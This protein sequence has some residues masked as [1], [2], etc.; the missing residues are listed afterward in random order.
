MLVAAPREVREAK[1][2]TVITRFDAQA[3]REFGASV[4]MSYGLERRHATVTANILVEADL[5]GHRTH[6]L[7]LLSNYV[8]A[9]AGG[10]M[11]K[12]GEPTVVNDTG[13]QA[14]WDARLLPG[15]SVIVDA[16]SVAVERAERHGVVTIVIRNSQ[17]TGC[18]AAYLGT[19]VE[20]GLFVVLTAANTRG[21]RI[22]PFGGLEPVFSPSP[23]AVGIPNGQD[24]ILVDVTM[25][26]VANSVVRQHHQRG[27]RLPSPWLQDA[28]GRPSD[29]PSTLY[30]EPKGTI[31]P[32]GGLDNG[33]KGFGLI[34]FVEALTLAMSGS[35]HGS[36]TAVD[37]QSVFLQVIDP[38]AFAG[39]AYFE[40]QIAWIA[41]ACRS[42][43][44]VT[45]DTKPRMPGERS[46][47][48]KREQLA[49]GV[50]MPA[51]ILGR[52]LDVA[53]EARV[54]LPVALS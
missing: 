44:P 2:T 39:R 35:G 11:T 47:A 26:S 43:D 32:L 40:E 18:H 23:F 13:P 7:D 54:A 48:L 53:T 41:A 46:M 1:E 24:P 25:A 4:L 8:A 14:L 12:A 22:A 29:D 36:D 16:M 33:H 6:G 17:H 37:S 49:T 21:Q 38:G 52:L 15:Q 20:R 31:M 45:R 34:L 50:R 10:E 19:A 28:E 9:L 51:D 30:D 42:S 27:D 3:L 5:L